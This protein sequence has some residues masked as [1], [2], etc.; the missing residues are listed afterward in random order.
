VVV[1]YT[2]NP[3][4]CLLL[5]WVPPFLAPLLLLSIRFLCIVGFQFVE[6]ERERERTEQKARIGCVPK[7]SHWKREREKERRRKK[8][9]FDQR[10]SFFSMCIA[11]REENCC[12]YCRYKD[13]VLWDEELI[14]VAPNNW[15]VVRSSCQTGVEELRREVV[16]VGRIP[17]LASPMEGGF[18]ISYRLFS[19][20]S[21]PSSY[22]GAP[23][24]NR[25]TALQANKEANH[26]RYPPL[27]H[28]C[29]R[30]LHR[31]S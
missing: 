7:V 6:R 9:C 20:I 12:C 8:D 28:V 29:A 10:R 17:A 11:K 26:G 1:L 30:I 18:C 19:N 4:W 24:S 2:L 3:Y 31:S 22:V 21:H 27:F 13:D 25:V 15:A 23:R 14:R 5:H 16:V